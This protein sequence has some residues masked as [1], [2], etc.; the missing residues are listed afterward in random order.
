MAVLVRI[1]LHQT[2]APLLCL[3]RLVDIGMLLQSQVRLWKFQP[4]NGIYQTAP[5]NLFGAVFVF[6]LVLLRCPER[7]AIIPKDGGDPN[8]LI[9]QDMRMVKLHIAA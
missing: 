8:E 6:M 2:T 5:N 4:L 3:N 7:F 9:G 1:R